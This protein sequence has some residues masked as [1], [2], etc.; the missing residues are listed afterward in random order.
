MTRHNSRRL[1]T[2]VLLPSPPDVRREIEF[3]LGSLN[4]VEYKSR[5]VVREMVRNMSAV[6][7]VTEHKVLPKTVNPYVDGWQTELTKLGFDES[8]VTRMEKIQEEIDDLKVRGVTPFP[9]KGR[10]TFEW[11]LAPTWD[12]MKRPYWLQLLTIRHLAED[13]RL[14]RVRECETCGRWFFAHRPSAKYR[15]HSS[16]CR[17]SYWRKTPEGR[18]KRRN[19]M[20]GY[21]QRLKRREEAQ[22]ASGRSTKRKMS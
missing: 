17:D 8:F 20:R 21:R 16:A 11:M 7:A 6:A 18:A 15:F 14:K 19:F 22:K 5:D 12:P 3:L 1:R 9:T 13:G 4:D 2:K 10:W